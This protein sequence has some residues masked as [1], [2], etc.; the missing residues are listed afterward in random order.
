[1]EQTITKEQA[2]GL[3]NT[4]IVPLESDE[5]EAIRAQ[6]AALDELE[7]ELAWQLEVEL[8]RQAQASNKE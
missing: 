4:G 6:E 3:I 2:L 5:R 7:Q 1:M 8:K